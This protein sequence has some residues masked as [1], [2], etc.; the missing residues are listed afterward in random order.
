MNKCWF[1]I[2]LTGNGGRQHSHHYV[3][4]EDIGD[5]DMSDMIECELGPYPS[6][7]RSCHW[8]RET[9]PKEFILRHIEYLRASIKN[10][11]QEIDIHQQYLDAS[12]V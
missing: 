9:P 2:W 6:S 11:Q 10:A 1:I 12:V 8:E 7:I 3:Y 4:W 5:D